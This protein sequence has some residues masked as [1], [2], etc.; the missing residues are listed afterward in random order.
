MGYRGLREKCS[1]ATRKS[2]PLFIYC[3]RGDGLF[4]SRNDAGT[5]G[6][7]FFRKIYG[8]CIINYWL[9]PYNSE[10]E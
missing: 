5:A 4:S 3:I 6:I 7:I 10:I 2:V 1:T 8:N 9:G